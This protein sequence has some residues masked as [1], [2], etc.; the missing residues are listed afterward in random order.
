MTVKLLKSEHE[1]VPK[2]KLKGPMGKT[3]VL[4]VEMNSAEDKEPVVYISE[5]VSES[6]EL[7]GEVRLMVTRMLDHLHQEFHE[8]REGTKH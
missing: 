4:C 1:V 7:M 5:W 6:C 8:I 3:I 2:E